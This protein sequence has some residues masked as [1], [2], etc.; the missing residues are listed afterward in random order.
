MNKIHLSSSLATKLL[1]IYQ[2]FSDDARIPTYLKL[3][4]NS[5]EAGS[6]A[7]SHSQPAFLTDYLKYVRAIHLKYHESKQ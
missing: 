4:N 1:N 7:G 6:K 2:F 5:T 3:L